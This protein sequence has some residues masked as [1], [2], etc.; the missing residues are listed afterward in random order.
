[1]PHRGSDVN[2]RLQETDLD[3]ARIRALQEIY[4]EAHRALTHWG[5]WSS[6]RRGLIP[7]LGAPAVW[8]QMKRDEDDGYGAEKG[9]TD[10]LQAKQERVH[11]GYDQ[12][13]AV[14]L[15][16]R[17]HAPGGLPVEIRVALKTAYVS[18][19]IPEYQFPRASG[20]GI[21]A[22]CERLEAALRFTRRF[23]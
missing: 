8:R 1:M 10:G 18:R 4:S 12:R 13:L 23:I 7:R 21:D 2:A 6:D 19:E 15:D 3:T 5:N 20:C 11:R 9:T 14:V 22:F 17:I 16:E